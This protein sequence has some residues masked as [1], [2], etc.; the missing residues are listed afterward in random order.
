MR[1]ISPILAST[2]LAALVVACAPNT[3]G[4]PGPRAERQCFLPMQITNFR[5]DSTRVFVRA[6]VS[7]VYELQLA[8][9][10]LDVDDS[11]QLA[12]VPTRGSSSLCVGDRAEV[13]AR[14]P[15]PA[16]PCS[17]HISRR[18]TNEDLAALPSRLR[19]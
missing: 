12:V 5:A 16:A 8:G 7:S 2:A 11:M 10:C 1:R 6:G 18:L 9:A 19:P 3:T 17:A 14:S 13:I 4:A 15:S